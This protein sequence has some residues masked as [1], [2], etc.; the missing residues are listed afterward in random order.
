MDLNSRVELLNL[1]FMG[2]EVVGG[3]IAEV[4]ST[5]TVVSELVRR[6]SANADGAVTT[7]IKCET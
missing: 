7:C 6:C 1:A 4:D 3:V 2:L 5:S